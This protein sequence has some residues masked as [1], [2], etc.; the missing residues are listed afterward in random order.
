MLNDF[1]RR[2]GLSASDAAGFFRCWN[3][4]SP[5]GKTF[6]P[7]YVPNGLSRMAIYEALG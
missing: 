7:M 3:T 5:T 2:F 1:Q 6:D 4:G